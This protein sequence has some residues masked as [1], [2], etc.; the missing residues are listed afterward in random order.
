MNIVCIGDSLTFGYGVNSNENWIH[1]VNS[2][3]NLSLTNKGFN[4][5]T[6]AGMLFRFYEDV[7]LNSPKYAFIMGGTNDF[8]LNYSVNNVIDN[9]ESMLIEAKKNNIEVILGIQPAVIPQLANKYWMCSDYAKVNDRIQQ[10]KNWLL[11]YSMQNSLIYINFYDVIQK[12][13]LTYKEN[14]LY[15]DGIHLTSKGHKIMAETFIT[16][17]SS[18]K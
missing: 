3:L 13:L 18:L 15:L 2:N 5:D 1:L 16:S 8:L 9:M 10:Y 17:L 7:T 6:T 12:S 11:T 4:G 14:E